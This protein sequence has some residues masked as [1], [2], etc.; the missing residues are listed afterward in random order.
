M[1][2]FTPG[3][4][5]LAI[6]AA[7]FYGISKGGLSAVGMLGVTFMAAA[8]PGRASTGIVLPLLVAA[9][10]IAAATF[11]EHV[12]WAHLRRLGWPVGLGVV[13]GWALLMVIPDAAFR[14]VIGGMVLG[15]LALQA[16]RQRFPRFDAALP[17]SPVFAWASGLLTG[18][19]TMVANAAGP[20]AS[21]YLI[22]LGF[23]K[24]QFVHTMAWLFLFVNLFKLPFSLQ[25]GLIN[26]GSLD[27]TARLVPAMLLGLWSGKR[28]IDRVPA[29]VFQN[30]VLTL[31]AA[32][33]A[34]LLVR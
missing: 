4:W 33:A 20:I 14:P 26:A 34:W 21:T 10:M 1:P 19:S 27:L 17:H 16:V 31:S 18:T 28:L 6:L 29:H 3:E 24:L 32:S 7:Y 2:S 22:V 9:D 30:L 12:H 13:A 5:L 25:L 15:M 8:V 11:R 23:A